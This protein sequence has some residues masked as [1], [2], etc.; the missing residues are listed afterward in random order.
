[1][2]APID[3]TAPV[4]N[5]IVAALPEAEREALRPH[6]RHVPLRRGEVLA[7]P[8]GV[9]RQAW[10]PLR[11]VVSLVVMMSDGSSAETTTIGP[12]GFVGFAA[13]FGDGR[14]FARNE[15]QVE[16]SAC[17]IDVPTLNAAMTPG[18]CLRHL[19]HRYAGAFTAQVLQTAACNALHSIEERSARWLLMAQD[20]AGTDTFA[21]T[22][23]YFAEMLGVR[24][25][26]VNLISRAF[27]RAGLIET[28]RGT[29]KIRDRSGLEGVTCECYRVM[30]ATI[31]DIFTSPAPA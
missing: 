19:L 24:R 11:G 9:I 18:S 17:V 28:S 14:A 1:M 23:T 8:G 6:L 25:A 4:R 15:V 2:I 3:A 5:R 21:L 16:G 12:E 30:R 7:E 26:S 31:E 27:Q 22:Q 13:L 20:R 10:F 29:V